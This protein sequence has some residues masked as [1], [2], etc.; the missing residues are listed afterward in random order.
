MLEVEF[1][2]SIL[3]LLSE[4]LNKTGIVYT[5]R[6]APGYLFLTIKT[7]NKYITISD[8]HNNRFIT[9]NILFDKKYIVN[10]L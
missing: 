9:I 6:D 3:T 1:A 7:K 4:L 5:P 2:A 8:I 10:P